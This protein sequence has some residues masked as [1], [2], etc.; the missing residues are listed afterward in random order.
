[1]KA[2]IWQKFPKSPL[3]LLEK[4]VN[5]QCCTRLI[6]VTNFSYVEIQSGIENV[7]PF[8]WTNT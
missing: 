6:V 7:A 4:A 8:S 2:Q 1:M 3:S 5:Y